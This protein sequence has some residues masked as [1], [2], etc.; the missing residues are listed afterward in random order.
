MLVAVRKERLSDHVEQDC[1]RMVDK[2][3]LRVGRNGADEM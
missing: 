2:L 3:G 1:N